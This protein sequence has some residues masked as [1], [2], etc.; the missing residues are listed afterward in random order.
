MLIA[1][2]AAALGAGIGQRGASVRQAIAHRGA[3]GYAP[4]HT[5]AAYELAL[6]Q[7]ADY[8][9]QDLAVT[10]DG[11][12]ICLHDDTLERT[13]NVV[14]VFPDRYARHSDRASAEKRWIANDFTLADIRRLDVGGW[15][16]QKFA[17]LRVVTW[18]DAVDLVRG[19]AGLYPEL[20]SPPLYTSR[21]VDML[22]LFVESVRSNGLDR[23][24]SLRRTPV[25]VQ[26][27][28]EA[29]V[30]RIASELPG[31]PRILLM[32]SFGEGGM[33]D[34][35]LRDIA[36]FASGIGPDKALLDTRPDVVDR[37]HAA[38]LTV[39]A[40][41]FRAANPGRFASVRDEMKHF[42]Y[43]VGIDALFTDNPDQFPREP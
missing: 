17:G 3:S 40:Y 28:D 33:T 26:S 11:A 20:K 7:R 35:R 41:T 27:F 32:E 29:T 8:V 21:G 25:I 24:E 37:A 38:G 14:E 34:S 23:P 10:R 19:K 18:Q 31:V 36:T 42:L 16:D 30:R 13:T 12:L 39:T 43:T 4:E 6:E 9:E 1:P 5:L 22:K 2:A 15:F